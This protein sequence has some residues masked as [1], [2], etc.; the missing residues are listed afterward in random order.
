MVYESGE[1]LGI[2]A[3]REMY[4]DLNQVLSITINHTVWRKRQTINMIASENVMSPLAMLVYLNDMMHRYAEGKPYKRFYQGLIYVDELEVKAQELMGDLLGTKYVDLR[5]ISGTTANATAFRT[6]TKPGDK[7]VVAPVQ[8]GAHVSHTRYGTLGALGIEQIEMPFDI[9]EWNIDVD[10]ARKLIEEV[11]PKIV[12]LGGSLYIFPHPTKEI[13][14]AA[15]S[16]GAKV[17]HDVAHVLGLIVGG[18]WENPLKLGADVIT[19]STHKTFPG[20]QG[21]VFATSNEEDY[22]EMGKVVFPMFVSNHHLHRLAAMAVTAIEMKLWGSEYARQVVRN[23]KALAEALASEGFKVVMESKGYTTSHQVVVDV[24]ELGRGTKV[25]KLLEDAHIIVNKNMLPWDR[26][27]DVKDPSGLR[28][29][30]QELTR[31]GMKEGEMKEIARLM[32]MVVIDKRSPA[33]VKEKV[34][35]FKKEF[36]EIHYGFKLTREDEVKLLKIMLHAE[37]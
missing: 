26:P 4:P 19:S 18:V 9:E 16:V 7:A 32:K 11:K 13:A 25:A 23:A 27:E 31:W 15:H 3:L 6:F 34:M 10:K 2:D 29:G 30:T 12:T 22:K 1:A 24:A 17:I 36:M 5:P 20:P 33:E 14:E 21:G 8:A 35:E 28:L 37:T